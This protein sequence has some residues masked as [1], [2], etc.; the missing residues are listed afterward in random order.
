M[1]KKAPQLLKYDVCGGPEISD[2][3]VISAVLMD[4]FFGQWENLD[5]LPLD[6]SRQVANVILTALHR[7][8]RAAVLREIASELAITAPSEAEFLKNLSEKIS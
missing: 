7:P 2:A 6:Q 5:P 3:D 8:D 4:Q 1:G